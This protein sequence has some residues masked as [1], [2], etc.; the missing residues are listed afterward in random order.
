MCI[1]CYLVTYGKGNPI[2]G[3]RVD[4]EIIEGDASP[5]HNFDY[6]SDYDEY[7][8]NYYNQDMGEVKFNI[9]KQTSSTAKVKATVFGHNASVTTSINF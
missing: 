7:G 4:Y 9:T 5:L 2:P 1:I 3:Q 8:G 6:T